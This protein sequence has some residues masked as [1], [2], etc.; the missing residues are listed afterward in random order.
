MPQGHRSNFATEAPERTREA[1]EMHQRGT[2]E[3]P[4]RATVPYAYNS[5]REA[6]ESGGKGWFIPAEPVTLYVINKI[7]REGG[8]WCPLV[9]MHIFPQ[10]LP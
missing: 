3:A 5:T 9:L 6:P 1:P 7:P 8:N 2:R 4:E 10:T